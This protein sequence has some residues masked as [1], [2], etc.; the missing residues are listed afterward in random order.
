MYVFVC[1]MWLAPSDRYMRVKSYVIKYEN[2]VSFYYENIMKYL[3]W[4]FFI[5]F[6]RPRTGDI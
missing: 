1:D 5:Y 4:N 6:K 2:F 3:V